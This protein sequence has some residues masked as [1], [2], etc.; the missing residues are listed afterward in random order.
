VARSWCDRIRA[1]LSHCVDTRAADRSPVCKHATSAHRHVSLAEDYMHAHLEEIHTI[2][3]VARELGISLRT[4]EYAF[5][6]TRGESPA[7][8]L[9]QIRLHAARCALL[10]P[11][12]PRTVTDLCLALGIGHHGRFSAAYRSQFDETPTQT[13][14]RR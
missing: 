7:Q 11:D 13:L 14:R 6:K 10:D 9:S 2:A 4:L 12:G 3:D 8:V 5:R 1:S